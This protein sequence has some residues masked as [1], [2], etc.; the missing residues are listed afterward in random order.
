MWNSEVKVENLEVFQ[1]A[2]HVTHSGIENVLATNLYYWNESNSIHDLL[3]C[4]S[5][6][7]K[8]VIEKDDFAIWSWKIICS[9]G[10]V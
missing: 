1:F 6:G 4:K 3:N 9:F 10:L 8:V 7:G 2:L 5:I